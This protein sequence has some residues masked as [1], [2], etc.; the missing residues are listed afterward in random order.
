M[1]HPYQQ[2][3]QPHTSAPAV[4]RVYQPEYL[5]SKCVDASIKLVGLAH[6]GSVCLVGWPAR[7]HRG[8]C[9]GR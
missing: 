7:S 6:S 4:F 2:R 8:G 9:S 1:T 3:A 5:Y